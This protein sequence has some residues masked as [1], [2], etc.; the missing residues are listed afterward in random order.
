MSLNRFEEALPWGILWSLVVVLTG[1]AQ[2]QIAMKYLI[3]DAETTGIPDNEKAP[4]TDIDNWPRVVQLAW[5][6][7][8]IGGAS[9]TDVSS[10]IVCPDGFRIPDR[11]ARIH[12]ITTARAKEEGHHINEVLGAFCGALRGAQGLVAHNVAFDAP[13]VGAEFFRSLGKDPL[14]DRPQT[15]TMKETTQLCGLASLSGYDYKWPTLQELHWELFGHGFASAHDAGADV[16]ACASCFKELVRRGLVEPPAP[17]PKMITT[18]TTSTVD[19]CMQ[20]PDW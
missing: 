8:S 15:C 20:E 1:T 7:V 16:A 9:S 17:A 12:G 3:F 19:R 10:F 14:E 13:T 2:T 6:V 5:A 11:A 18:E 4:S